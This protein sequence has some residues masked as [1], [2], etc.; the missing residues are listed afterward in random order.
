MA[1]R[2]PLIVGL[3][4]GYDYVKVVTQDR[5]EIF[6]TSVSL[7]KR[8]EI[9]FL[10]GGSQ[11]D[12]RHYDINGVV[13]A[14]GDDVEDPS[15]TR[16]DEFTFSDENFS[17][18]LDAI[19]KVVPPG[20]TV[21]AFTGLPLSRIYTSSG[22]R[23]EFVDDHKRDAWTRPARDPDGET[24]PQI[25]DVTVMP[26]AVAAWFD[27]IVGPDLVSNEERQNRDTVVVD[28]GGRT[29]DVATFESGAFKPHRSTTLDQGMLDIAEIAN[30]AA[31]D[32]KPGVTRLS[33]KI[34]RSAIDTGIFQ[35]AGQ[36]IDIREEITTAKRQL[37]RRVLT[38]VMSIQARTASANRQVLFVGG[39]ATALQTELREQ[40]PD[41][42][43]LPAPQLANARGMWKVGM[44]QEQVSMEA[45]LESNC[46]KEPATPTRAKPVFL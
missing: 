40:L 7:T 2:R 5:Q 32:Q 45:L 23:R 22:R 33:H 25:V 20:A 26:Q 14:V 12:E 28:I 8:H 31:R 16:F 9:R 29:T 3:D 1:Q 10:D 13:Y 39:G 37:A 11:V 41:L 27:F 17:L 34:I 6:P 42:M 19:R 35:F 18:I 15:E 38:H 4:D 21:H 24:L 43:L 44:L 30:R 36:L 46:P